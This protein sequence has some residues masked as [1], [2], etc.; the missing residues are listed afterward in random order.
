MLDNFKEMPLLLKMM[1]IHSGFCLL[2]AIIVLIPRDSF[3]IDDRSVSYAEWISSGTGPTLSALT[4]LLAAAGFLLLKKRRIGCYIY[5]ACFGGL[6]TIYPAL[7]SD[8]S[9]AIFGL[10]IA[11]ALG[12]YLFKN[13]QVRAYLAPN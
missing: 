8:Y 4:F 3:G 7:K 10:V 1:A 12:I 5:L 9:S 2:A 13:A 6:L 11:S